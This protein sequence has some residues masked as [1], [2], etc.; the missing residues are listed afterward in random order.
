M[1]EGNMMLINDIEI[2]VFVPTGHLDSKIIRLLDLR[3]FD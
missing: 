2:L 1:N 3:L